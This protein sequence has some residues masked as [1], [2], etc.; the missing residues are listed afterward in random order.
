MQFLP[1]I[2]TLLCFWLLFLYVLITMIH[3]ALLPRMYVPLAV[4]IRQRGTA[5][6]SV[7]VRCCKFQPRK[8]KT[9]S[10]TCTTSLSASAVCRPYVHVSPHDLVLLKFTRL[11]ATKLFV[12]LILQAAIFCNQNGA[13]L[14][15]RGAETFIHL[16]IWERP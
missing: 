10:D 15:V 9:L 6:V 2:N 12:L 11:P 8:G 13:S 3:F 7:C 1:Y 5:H 14:A 4:K 16:L